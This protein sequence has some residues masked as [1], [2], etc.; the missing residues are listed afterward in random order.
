MDWKEYCQYDKRRITIILLKLID[1]NIE[2]GVQA[3]L[4]TI[5]YCIFFG[6]EIKNYNQN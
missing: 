6:F 2:Y 5:S 1:G 4:I 3:P